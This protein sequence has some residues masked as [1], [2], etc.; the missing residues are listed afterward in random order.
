MFVIIL[1]KVKFINSA[2]I[3]IDYFVIMKDLCS[4]GGS[5][6]HFC[7]PTSL[8]LKLPRGLARRRFSG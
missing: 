4:H 2:Q 8:G 1:F 5:A 6:W 7:S 3:E